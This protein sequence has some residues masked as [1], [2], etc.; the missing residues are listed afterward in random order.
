MPTLAHLLFAV[1]LFSA[2][3][4]GLIAGA[5]FAFSTFVMNALARLPP[6]QGIAAMQSINVAVINPWFM[7]VFL[8]TALA[9]LLLAVSS[10]LRWQQPGAAYL[11]VGSLLYVVGTF[12][13]TVVFNVPLNDALA[14]LDPATPESATFWA[15]YVKQWTVWNHV[16]T[17]AALAA[18]AAFALALGQRGAS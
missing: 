3:G 13:I 12:L 1:K 5:F 8:G 18:A 6:P 10:L 2:L 7:S 16:R 11:L 14:N 17:V 9:C 4:C 15:T